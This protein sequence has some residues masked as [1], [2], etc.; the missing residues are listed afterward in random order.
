MKETELEEKKMIR[1]DG[2]EKVE[3]GGEEEEKRPENR[4]REGWEWGLER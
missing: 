4:G 1:R 2:V 3:R